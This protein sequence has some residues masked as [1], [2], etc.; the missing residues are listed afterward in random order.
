MPL[1]V[2]LSGNTQAKSKDEQLG[3]EYVLS[4][5]PS[6]GLKMLVSTMDDGNHTDGPIETATLG[7]SR[8][9]VC[10]D[11]RQHVDLHHEQKIKLARLCRSKC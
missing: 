10:G 11:A 4:S 7:L 3:P 8:A 5:M 9:H 1:E 2:G 6:E